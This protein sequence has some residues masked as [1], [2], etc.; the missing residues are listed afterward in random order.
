M[1]SGARVEEEVSH[2]Q[3]L[4]ELG[5]DDPVADVGREDRAARVELPVGGAPEDE[6]E[7]LRRRLGGR[8]VHRRGDCAVHGLEHD[9][10]R[11]HAEG[12][13]VEGEGPADVANEV[14]VQLG[15]HDD[16]HDQARDEDVGRRHRVDVRLVGELVLVHA[17]VGDVSGET[18]AQNLRELVEEVAARIRRQIPALRLIV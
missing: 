8:E 11:Q 4:Y 5:E 18:E 15:V 16:S 7:D 3:H 14:P 1:K 2:D 17:E 12:L 13:H 6:A 9:Q 10:L